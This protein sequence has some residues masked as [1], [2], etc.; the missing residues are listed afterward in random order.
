MSSCLIGKGMLLNCCCY[1]HMLILLVFEC[2]NA[3]N[4]NAQP[5]SKQHQQKHNNLVQIFRGLK[6]NF[7]LIFLCLRFITII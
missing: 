6:T 4:K 7:I 2:F 3:V 5:F 1:F